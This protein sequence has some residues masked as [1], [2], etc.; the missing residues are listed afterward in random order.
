[1]SEILHRFPSQPTRSAGAPAMTPMSPVN[2]P[3]AQS[4][5]EACADCARTRGCVECFEELVRRFQSPLLHYL[6]RRTGSRHDAEDLVQETFLLAHRN[7]GRYRS[8]WRFSTWLF[9]IASR[10]ACS[11]N[12]RNRPE[13][14]AGC[15]MPRTEDAGPLATVAENELR[16]TLWDAAR[17]ILDP[18]AFTALWLCY[19]E[20]M[21][22]GE[23]GRVLGRRANAVRIL[24][25]RARAKLALRLD[26]S[27]NAGVVP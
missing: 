5:T 11:A 8:S 25:H 21:P 14:S 24:L 4:T 6:I 1:M 7:L 10:L 20:S 15:R 16:G 17:Q 12:R 26:Q 13:I 19:V 2:H 18:D 3:L 27:E 22:A 23:I 9:T